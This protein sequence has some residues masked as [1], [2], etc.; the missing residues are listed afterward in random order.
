MLV[1]VV[2]GAG[3]VAATGS[4]SPWFPKQWDPR[5]APIAAEVARLRGLDFEHPVSV[6]FLSPAE[7]EKEVSSDPRSLSHDARA[8]IDRQAADFR[9]LGLI[10]GN[11]D[12]AKALNTTSQSGTLAFYSYIHKNIVVRGTTLD[13]E[14]RVTLAHE[15][16]HV[17]QDQH[18]DLTKLYNRADKSTTGDTGAFLAL[19]EGDAVRVEDLYKQ[20]LST[21]EQHEYDREYAAEGERVKKEA[22]GVPDVIQFLFGAP[23]EFGPATPTVLADGG[24]HAAID[25]ALTGP[26]PSTV[27]FIQPGNV[28]APPSVAAPA[29]PEG[30]TAVGDPESFGAFETYLTLGATIDP[31]RALD[32]ADVVANGRAR[33][34]RT[35]GRDCYAVSLMPR[36]AASRPFLEAAVREWVAGKPDAAMVPGGSN[37][38]FRACDPGK[39]AVGITKARLQA[40]DDLLG[41]R[42]GLTTGLAD[43]GN[44]EADQAR[45]VARVFVHDAAARALLLEIGDGTPT[46]AQASRLRDTASNAAL[47]CVGNSDAQLH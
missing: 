28:A 13:A 25:A 32:A 19:V 37:V 39:K 24:G 46:P 38:T 6:R 30:A 45:C 17:L 43:G 18:F 5:V 3:L 42:T 11:V 33:T 8:E 1:V 27:V 22:V 12:L 44:L 16:T 34:Y 35:N 7:F 26:V 2:V 15:L 4:T 47:Q 14:H 21:A 23:Y 20:S 31:S 10:N 36:R 9:A 41:I 40:L 29:V